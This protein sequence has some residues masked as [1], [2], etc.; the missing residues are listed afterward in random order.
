[1]L[2]PCPTHSSVLPPAGP[3]FDFRQ[4]TS[5]AGV[6]KMFATPA[7]VLPG[8]VRRV[9][10][11]RH[12]QLRA[13]AAQRCV[14]RSA[15]RVRGATGM[16]R[17]RAAACTGPATAA[18]PSAGARAQVHFSVADL[19]VG[20]W[21][22]EDAAQRHMS[23]LIMAPILF[24]AMMLGPTGLGAYFLVRYAFLASECARAGA[25]PV[26]A[27]SARNAACVRHAARCCR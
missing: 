18:A 3:G 1:M 20:K 14:R 15:V 10:A 12:T 24:A 13:A 7:S 23:R 25:L 22:A 5:L 8:W 6:A 16:A 26:R 19:W 4:F 17:L 27:C 9:R 2:V 11:G 21:I